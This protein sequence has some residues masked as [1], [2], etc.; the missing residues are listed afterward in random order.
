MHTFFINT[1]KKEFSACD[2]LL[3]IHYEQKALVSLECLMAN[4]YDE[5]KGYSSCVKKMC[6]MIDGYSEINNT[7]NLIVY[8]DLPEYKVYSSIARDEF[9][10]KAREE[11]C[12]A[13]HILFTHVIRESILKE[14]IDTGREPKRVL[15]MF[16]QEKKFATFTAAPD[17]PRR[18][19]VKKWLFQLIGIPEEK[20]I[21]RVAK[22]V[23]QS[24]SEDLVSTFGE[25]IAMQ[26][27][28]EIMPGLRNGYKNLL[29]LWH[30][31]IINEKNIPKA[32]EALFDRIVDINRV[33]SERVGI[34][35][36]ACPYDCYASRVNKSVA[37]LSE[38]NVALYLLKCVEF[39]DEFDSADP[40][41]RKNL[42][43]FHAYTVQEIAPLLKAKKDIFANKVAE[44]EAMTE[45]YTELK[46][47]PKLLAFDH[48]KFGLDMYGD[49]ATEL[50]VGNVQPVD[51]E[52]ENDSDASGDESNTIKIK[53]NTKEVAIVERKARKLFSRDEYKEFDYN[54]DQNSGNMLK[55]KT[56]PEEYVE[57]AKIV[58]K[59]HLD[60]L[61]KLKVH[62]SNVLSNYAGKSKENKPA[63][64]RVG[65][66]RYASPEKEEKVIETVDSVSQKAYETMVDQYMRFCA[67]RSVAITDIEE[68]CN[69]FVSRIHQI[70]ESL[71]KIKAVA[72]GLAIAIALLYVP[73]IV[74]QFEAIVKNLLTL[75]TAMG[76]IAVPGIL[77]YVIFGI[78]SLAQRKKYIK[79][80]EEFKEKSDLALEENKVAAQKY[81]QLLATV[82]PA[83]RW[84]YEYKLD[85]EYC[86]ECCNVA[87]AKVEHHRKNLRKRMISLQNMIADLEFK[88][89][90][91]AQL[92]DDAVSN[93][94]AI[95]YNL[96]FCS[97]KTNQSFYSVIDKRFLDRENK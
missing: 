88:E 80:W 59:H 85:V 55:K 84:V 60:Y 3:D 67:G 25:E 41:L 82:I 30:D 97:G 79:A 5:D 72:I 18:M 6:D 34:E 69:W 27:S 9:H 73:F 2:V 28:G 61:K 17:D 52:E 16:G 81:D 70:T 63:L 53:G 29:D 19:A 93:A 36:V 38:L 49:K 47:S 54:C 44:I 8:I 50:V 45:T 96:P 31:E 4:W 91:G 15:L 66:S 11:C 65:G 90:D 56:T 14:L 64:L 32:N 33:E 23:D 22:K 21:E 7:F 10:D 26:F 48:L 94:E 75:V 83:L 71:K 12:N 57:Q 68:Q 76:S 1:S 74:I 24:G 40:E 87:D 13:M 43:E 62:V 20:D 37:V 39:D 92:P 77:L 89:C 51:T 42:L 95:D 78:V 58:R 46:L 86:L 35:S